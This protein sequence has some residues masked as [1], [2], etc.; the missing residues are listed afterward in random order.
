MLNLCFHFA[1]SSI[2]LFIFNAPSASGHH[3]QTSLVPLTVQIQIYNLEGPS[4][5]DLTQE[6]EMQYR[7]LQTALRNLLDSNKSEHFNYH[8]LLDQLKMHKAKRIA[9]A[10][11]YAFTPYNQAIKALDDHYGQPK[12]VFH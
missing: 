12:A 3:Q 5:P 7:M 9:L 10:L 2:H 1:L 8:T 6:D 11:S 4:F